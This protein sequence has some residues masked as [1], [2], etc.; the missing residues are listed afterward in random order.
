MMTWGFFVIGRAPNDEFVGVAPRAPSF[1]IALNQMSE[2]WPRSATLQQMSRIVKSGDA[3]KAI[4]AQV[5]TTDSA[6]RT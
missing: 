5:E 1:E 6:V 3:D 4:V 2:G